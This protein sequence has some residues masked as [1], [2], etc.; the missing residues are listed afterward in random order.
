[1]ATQDTLTALRDSIAELKAMDLEPIR[2]RAALFGARMELEDLASTIS[3]DTEADLEAVLLVT[4]AAWTVRLEHVLT[5]DETPDPTTFAAV[6]EGDVRAVLLALGAGESE[7]GNEVT[8]RALAK[9]REL[10]KQG[11]KI[12]PVR[13]LMDRTKCMIGGRA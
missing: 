13:E 5:T 6:V 1:M 9:T 2:A 7:T 8:D 10:G 3:N 4:R 12:I 11:V